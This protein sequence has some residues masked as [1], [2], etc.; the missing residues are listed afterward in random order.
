MHLAWTVLPFVAFAGDFSG[1]F[2]VR[3]CAGRRTGGLTPRMVGRAV[4]SIPEAYVR[5]RM[6]YPD[7]LWSRVLGAVRSTRSLAVDLGAGTGLATEELARRFERVVAV[8]TD[9][10]MAARIAAAPNVEVRVQR[11]E[12]AHFARG[13]VDLVVFANALHWMAAEV[14]LHG[15]R[16][17]LAP[18]GVVAAWRPLIPRVP[19][20]LGAVLSEELH[21]RWDRFR[22]PRLRTGD[23]TRRALVDHGDLDVVSTELVTV[24]ETTDLDGVVGFLSTVSYVNAYARST[25]DRAAYLTELR[26][27]LAE[28]WAHDRVDVQVSYELAVAAAKGG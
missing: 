5:W 2:E 21:G 6:R 20:P 22:H 26:A 15:A 24:T 14:V 23:W 19:E 12:E 3:A 1:V 28:S 16:S 18:G 7:D 10:D 4:E 9:P 13:S 17:W 25:G 11:A 27:R 8:E